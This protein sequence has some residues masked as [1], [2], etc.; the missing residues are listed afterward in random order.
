MTTRLSIVQ[1]SCVFTLIAAEC[2]STCRHNTQPICLGAEGGLNPQRIFGP[3]RGELLRGGEGKGTPGFI[4]QIG[5]CSCGWDQIFRFNGF[6]LTQFFI[7]YSFLF[8]S[9]S[10]HAIGAIYT[11]AQAPSVRFVVLKTFCIICRQQI[12]QVEFGSHRARTC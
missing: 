10:M 8:R 3:S 2:S 6:S 12:D 5:H 11:K 7:T 9:H 4:S 1:P